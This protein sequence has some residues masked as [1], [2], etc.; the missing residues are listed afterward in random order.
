M[1]RTAKVIRRLGT[2]DVRVVKVRK[3]QKLALAL[4]YVDWRV[5]VN[6]IGAHYVSSNTLDFYMSSLH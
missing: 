5:R 1:E 4:P 6:L 2:I 3:M